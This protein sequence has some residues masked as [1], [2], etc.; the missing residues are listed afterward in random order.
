M[1]DGFVVVVEGCDKCGKTSLAA[2]LGDLL[3]WPVVHFS[4]P[5]TPGGATQEYLHALAERPG[6]FIADRFYLGESVYGPLYRST[7]PIPGADVA[8]LETVLHARGSLLVLMEDAA[9][10][11]EDRFIRL[12]E[13]FARAQDVPV[14]LREFDRLW[15]ESRLAKVRATLDDKLSLVVAG[16]V[17]RMQLAARVTGL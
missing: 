2:S 4:Q 11:V 15:R 16:V 12:E 10:R 5:K 7:P 9:W 6:P 17:Q 14:I 3:K 13:D 1:S 8:I